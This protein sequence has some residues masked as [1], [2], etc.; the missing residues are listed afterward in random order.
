MNV[1]LSMEW[2]MEAESLCLCIIPSRIVPLPLTSFQFILGVMFPRDVV[3]QLSFKSL[4]HRCRCH[5][6]ITLC[7]GSW[8]HNVYEARVIELKLGE[9]RWVEIKLSWDANYIKT[10]TIFTADFKISSWSYF[11]Q[12]FKISSR[13]Y[14][15][16]KLWTIVTYYSTLFVG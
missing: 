7:S 14:C 1:T 4:D 15:Y 5:I 2:L 3:L 9:L 6:R 10:T 13:S 8:K 11:Q 16:L 12:S